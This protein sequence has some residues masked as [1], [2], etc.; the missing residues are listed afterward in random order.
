[1]LT[2][3]MTWRII[4]VSV[5]MVTGTF[6]LFLWERAQGTG[7]EE[8]RTVAVN[9]LVIAEAFYL[10]NARFLTAPVLNRAGLLGNRY[11]LIAIVLVVGFQQLFTYLPLMQTFFGTAAIDAAAWARILAF[12]LTLFALVELEKALLRWRDG[13]KGL[14]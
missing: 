5:L 3:F 13:R 1:L 10:L 9:A 6:G 4:F 12:G 7:L 2:G 14:L 8:A 11:V